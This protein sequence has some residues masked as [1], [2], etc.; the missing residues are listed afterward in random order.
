MAI[1]Y[2][3]LDTALSMINK[4]DKRPLQFSDQSREK[5]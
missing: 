2:K 3:D 4:R 5:L 1:D